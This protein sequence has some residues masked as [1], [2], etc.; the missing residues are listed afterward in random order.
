[1]I[2]VRMTIAALPGMYPGASFGRNMYV[3]TTDPAPKVKRVKALTVTF[4]VCPPVLLAFHASVQ[5]YLAY[6]PSKGVKFRISTAYSKVGIL[7][8]TGFE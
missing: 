8:Q 1:M 2:A 6:R 7:G 4:L 3:P 5:K